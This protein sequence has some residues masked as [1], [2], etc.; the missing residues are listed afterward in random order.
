MPELPDVEVFR[1]IADERALDRPIETVSIRPDGMTMTVA[2]DTLRAAL[3]GHMLTAAER[4]GKHLFLRSGEDRGRWLR[5]HFG[6][7]GSLVPLEPGDGEPDHTRLRL[8]FRGGSRLAYRCPRK[9]GE[10]GLA[11]APRTFARE[12]GLGPD[13]LHEGVGPATF[14]DRLHDRGGIVKAA[15]MDQ[16]LIAGLGNVYTDE[17]LFHAGLH[18]ETPM[19]ALSDGDLEVLFGTVRMVIGEAIDAHA[20]VA[21]HREADVPCPRGDGT[22]RKSEVNGRPTYHCDGHQPE[23]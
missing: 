5:L 17:I 9:L 15:L 14:R 2:E 12:Q 22:V 7:T 8:D 3:L 23:R 11:D 20:D 19:D 4:W 6:M 10:I 16:A 1:R 21:R 18:P 13:P